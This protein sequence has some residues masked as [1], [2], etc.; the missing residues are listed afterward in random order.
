[1]DIFTIAR[2]I[3]ADDIVSPTIPFIPPNGGITPT[4]IVETGG[5]SISL[6]TSVISIKKGEKAKIRVVISTD[7][8]EIKEFSFVISYN[9]ALFKVVDGDS[10]K[11]GLQIPYSN[12]YFLTKTNEVNEGAGNL[13]FKAASSDT[14]TAPINNR[15]IAEFEVEALSD[16]VG[17]FSITKQ[18]SSLIDSSNTN[19]LKISNSIN[20]SVS[21]NTVLTSPTKSPTA[22][23]TIKPTMVGGGSITPRTGIS[24]DLGTF[25]SIMLG[26][27][28]VVVGFYFLKKKKDYDLQR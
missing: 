2:A 16:G 18:G 23:P 24:D 3:G 13:T 27:I 5:P 22:R 17:E 15:V 11:L 25:G 28:F 7:S 21:T 12:N 20:I 8:E 6:E 14:G 1:M 4:P 9:K 26:A 19:I 10:G